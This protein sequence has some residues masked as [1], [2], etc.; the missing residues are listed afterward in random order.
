V[1]ARDW[2]NPGVGAI[3]SNVIAHARNGSIVVMH[4]APSG[5]RGETIAALPSILTHYGH[6]G[7]EFV[8]V[9]EL[10]GHNFIYPPNSW[11]LG[12]G[13]LPQLVRRGE[14]VTPRQHDRH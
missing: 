7:Y 13:R 4:D 8:T 5:S 6:R 14:E 11:C 10:L 12:L 9:A 1:D 3:V 2:A